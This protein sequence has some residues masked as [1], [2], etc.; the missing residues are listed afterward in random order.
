MEKIHVFSPFSAYFPPHYIVVEKGLLCQDHLSVSYRTHTTN[1]LHTATLC[2]LILTLLL[3]AV[4]STEALGGV[5]LRLVL[6]EFALMV[7]AQGT[8]ERVKRMHARVFSIFGWVHYFS[9]HVYVYIGK[10][11]RRPGYAKIF[12]MY[13]HV[14]VQCTCM[15]TSLC[16]GTCMHSP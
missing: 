13:M 16:G 1:I 5:G 7:P 12:P 11:L 15:C 14:H 6:G 3:H 10:F 2:Y 9:I 4:L 8:L